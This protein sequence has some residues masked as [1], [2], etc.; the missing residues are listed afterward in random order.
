MGHPVGTGGRKHPPPCPQGHR[1]RVT[2]GTQFRGAERSTCCLLLSC[3]QLP[4]TPW[5]GAHPAPLSMGVSRQEYWSGLLCCPPGDLPDPG[6]E[7]M[8][9]MSPALAGG[10]FTSSATWDSVLIIPVLLLLLL[11]S[12][13]SR[14]RLCATP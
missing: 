5:T 13:F 3:V 12:C 4:A 11:L 14:V 2:R 1:W 7:Q 6:I 8:S 10:F 9:L